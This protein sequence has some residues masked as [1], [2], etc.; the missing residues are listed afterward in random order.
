MGEDN[1]NTNIET[2]KKLITVLCSATQC[3]FKNNDVYYGSCNNPL[4]LAQ[5]TE[6]LGGRI[7]VSECKCAGCEKDCKADCGLDV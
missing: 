2:L 5:Y 6:L 1:K 4:I 3:R 7:Y